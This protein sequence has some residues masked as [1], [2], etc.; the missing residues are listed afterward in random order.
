MD[1]GAEGGPRIIPERN[2]RLDFGHELNGRGSVDARPLTELVFCGATPIPTVGVNHDLLDIAVFRL[3]PSTAP[4]RAPARLT[5]GQGE[6]LVAP[7]TQVFL[8]VYPAR[9][10][11]RHPW[12]R[13]L[14]DR[15]LRLLFASCGG[16]SARTREVRVPTLG[17]RTMLHDATTLGGTRLAGDGPRHGACGDR[18]H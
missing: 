2:A 6:Q 3:G 4:G 18:H 7:Q 8:A 10:A 5:I 1:F 12:H 9:L 11:S 13:D 16:F 14:T 15:V 17:A